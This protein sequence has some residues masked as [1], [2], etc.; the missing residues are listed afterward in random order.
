MAD[1]PRLNIGKPV[2]YLLL[3]SCIAAAANAA[4]GPCESPEYRGFDFWL[5]E[6]A[7]HT[8]DG[9]L[10][11]VNRIEREYGGCVIHE[12]YS[13]E[14]GFAGESLNSYD[15]GRQ[16]WHQT[17]VDN[18]GSLLLLEGGLIDGKMVLKG[19]TI[20]EEQKTTLHRITW[21]P[22]EDGSVR[23]FWQSTNAAG[24]WETAFD[25]RYTRR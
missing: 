3:A 13:S 6:W 11:G 23:Q 12:R 24:D 2:G 19:Q 21:T 17:W 1:R 9:K 22:N 16:V 14:S 8:P 18:A 10:A 5:G 25:G 7:V 15:P 20:D 4:D